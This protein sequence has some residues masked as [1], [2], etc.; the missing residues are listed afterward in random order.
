MEMIRAHVPHYDIDHYL[1][2][3][4]ERAKELVEAGSVSAFS[5]LAVFPKGAAG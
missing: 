1:A 2:A 3:D 4:I 5:P